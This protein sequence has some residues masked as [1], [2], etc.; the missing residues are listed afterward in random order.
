M[1]WSRFRIVETM[2]DRRFFSSSDIVKMARLC[3]LFSSFLLSCQ[4]SN[5]VQFP[6]FDSARPYAHVE[7]FR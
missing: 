4:R 7:T 1:G 3:V 2:K 5:A 6:P